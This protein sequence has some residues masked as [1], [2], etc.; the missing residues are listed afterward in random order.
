M[1]FLLSDD[2]KQI[3]ETARKVGERFSFDYWR[4]LDA[5]KRFPKDFWK[6]VCAAGLSGVPFPEEYGGSG[7]S[8]QEMALIVE[9]LA[10]C[11][12]GAPVGQLFMINPIF[13]GVSI[14]RFGSEAMKSELLP[15]II[16]GE[17]NCCMALTEPDT[18]S[19]SLEIKTFATR[20]GNGWRLNGRKTWI[21]GVDAAQKMLVVARTTKSQ[22]VKRRTEGL[23]MFIVNVERQGLSFT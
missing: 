22:E 11:G 16:G 14:A 7:L 8:M 20:D 21:T 3:V 9:T 10:A 12:G 17:I 6:A 5:K 4:E 18:G 23:S 19:N 15:Q 2:Q 1:D 13:G